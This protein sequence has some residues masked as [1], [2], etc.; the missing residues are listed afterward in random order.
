MLALA[1]DHW[2][3]S[4][5]RCFL[6]R[7]KDY[8]LNRMRKKKD[9]R[10]ALEDRN[11]ELRKRGN[12]VHVSCGQIA[13]RK[14]FEVG[15]YWINKKTGAGSMLVRNQK[16]YCRVLKLA[17]F[18]R[19]KAL[20]QA[21]R[22]VASVPPVVRRSPARA[23]M[24]EEDPSQA[25]EKTAKKKEWELM[26]WL[27]T[28]TNPIAQKSAVPP[29]SYAKTT[30]KK[31]PMRPP[32]QE[33][34]TKTVRLAHQRMKSSAEKTMEKRVGEIEDEIASFSAMKLKLRTLQ[35]EKRSGNPAA[36]EDAIRTL[37]KDVGERQAR[38]RLLLGEINSLKKTFV[39]K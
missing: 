19:N 5:Y 21:K 31:A 29:P 16:I 28:V 12:I 26:Q 24:H 1:I 23:E 15:F 25:P 27:Q 17:L 14:W 8:T 18:W 39:K 36:D 38:V 7:W 9:V 22:K 11:R 10:D 32:A 20:Q 3:K 2:A 4:K 6:A 33:S 13:L 34:A 37:K 30:V 35:K